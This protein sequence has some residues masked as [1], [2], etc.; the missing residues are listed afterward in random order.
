MQPGAVAPP[1]GHSRQAAQRCLAVLG[2]WAAGLSAERGQP[3][4]RQLRAVL[5]PGLYG[6]CGCLSAHLLRSKRLV[7]QTVPPE[8]CPA[9]PAMLVCR[10]HLAAHDQRVA[11]GASTAGAPRGLLRALMPLRRDTPH[12]TPPP[13]PPNQAHWTP[14]PLPAVAA[15]QEPPHCRFGADA[16]RSSCRG[17]HSRHPSCGPGPAGGRCTG[18]LRPCCVQRAGAGAAAGQPRVRRVLQRA[19]GAQRAP[20]TGHGAARVLQPGA[21]ELAGQVWAVLTAHKQLPQQ[22]QGWVFCTLCARHQPGLDS[23]PRLLRTRPPH[24]R[25]GSLHAVCPVVGSRVTQ[26]QSQ[27]CQLC[28]AACRRQ[29]TTCGC[30][31]AMGLRPCCAQVA[32]R[33]VTRLRAQMIESFFTPAAAMLP[34]TPVAPMTSLALF[35]T[36]AAAL[37]PTPEALGRGG[38]LPHPQPSPPPFGPQV[39]PLAQ[40]RGGRAR[41][42]VEH[43]PPAAGPN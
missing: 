30:T 26:Q 21:S 24:A 11:D 22:M 9:A 40:R 17:S 14:A 27:G 4:A 18:C 5:S 34:P 32:Q 41:A 2:R 38:K 8:P 39:G 13:P 1:R 15:V 33:R 29:R 3:C 37:A 36:P 43:A 6:P 19:A 7:T 23:A 42:K 35:S 16:G 31:H 12:T 20:C 25:L 28:W 10:D